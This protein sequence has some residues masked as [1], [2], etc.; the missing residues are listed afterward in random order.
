MS[1]RVVTLLNNKPRDPGS[2]DPPTISKVP[3]MNQK[4]TTPI[5][6]SFSDD[7]KVNDSFQVLNLPILNDTTPLVNITTPE[8]PPPSSI[9]NS[10]LNCTSIVDDIPT[11]DLSDC[12]YTENTSLGSKRS[13]HD[14]PHTTCISNLNGISKIPAEDPF[15]DS[16]DISF[17]V[18]SRES[19]GKNEGHNEDS[20]CENSDPF[21]ILRKIRIS[22]VNR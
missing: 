14:T 21:K 16:M 8:V 17:L 18:L 10:I 15:I 5:V 7:W 20:L 12:S 11:P 13:M 2:P 9:N 1:A 22:N 4:V 19:H 3:Q 6:S